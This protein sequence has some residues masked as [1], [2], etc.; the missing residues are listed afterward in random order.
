[1]ECVYDFS[2]N[3]D[4]PDYHFHHN[5]CCFRFFKTDSR[6]R[7]N[8]TIEDMGGQVWNSWVELKNLATIDQAALHLYD[9]FLEQITAWKNTQIL[10]NE[11]TLQ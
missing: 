7:F 9:C 1:M 6:T 8:F 10:T 4:K 11:L 2:N 3:P 5:G